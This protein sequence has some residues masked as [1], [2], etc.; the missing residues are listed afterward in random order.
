MSDTLKKIAAAAAVVPLMWW[1]VA[2]NAADNC[3]GRNSKP[4]A[5]TQHGVRPDTGEAFTVE[6][7]YEQDGRLCGMTVDFPKPAGA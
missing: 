3:N 6:G 2:P 7:T 1:T 5:Y 4:V